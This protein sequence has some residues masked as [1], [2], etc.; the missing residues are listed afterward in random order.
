[1]KPVFITVIVAGIALAFAL[2]VSRGFD[3]YAVVILVF[4]VAVGVLAIATLN[5]WSGGSV[6]PGRCDECGGLISPNAPYCKHCHAPKEA[7]A[8]S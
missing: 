8:G 5:R 6:Q 2:G 7:K 1:V 3:A 4:I